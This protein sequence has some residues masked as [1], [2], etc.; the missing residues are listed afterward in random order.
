MSHLSVL[1]LRVTMNKAFLGFLF[2][3]ISTFNGAVSV[4]QQPE[5]ISPRPGDVLQGEVEI[6]GTIAGE[7]L[8]SYDVLFAYADETTESW[9]LISSGEGQV[10]Q[11]TLAIWDTTAIADG[12]YR[13]RI[14]VNYEEGEPY[15]LTIANLRVRNYTA[16]ETRTPEPTLE[17]EGAQT[18]TETPVPV[19]LTATPMAQNPMEI[20]GA[21]FMYSVLIGAGIAAG[22]LLLLGLRTMGRK[23]YRGGR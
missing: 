9:F 10:I 8:K 1:N 3:I 2:L 15:V 13:L 19:I 22:I 20:S 17:K 18:G 23:L 5:V 11:G 7:A 14:Q 16:V 12:T 6:Q 4:Y 21:R